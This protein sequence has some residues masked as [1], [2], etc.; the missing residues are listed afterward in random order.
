MGDVLGT[1]EAQYELERSWFA[2]SH[3]FQVHVTRHTVLVG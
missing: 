2:D 1:S 3:M